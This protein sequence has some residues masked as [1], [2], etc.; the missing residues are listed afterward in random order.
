MADTYQRAA[1]S[2]GQWPNSPMVP[3]AALTAWSSLLTGGANAQAVGELG[4]IA[5]EWQ[6][7][8]GRRLQEDVVL[9]QR[10]TRSTRP[11]QVVAAYADFWRK[12]GE[13]YSNEVSTMMKLMTDVTSRTLVAAQSAAEEVSTRLSHHEAR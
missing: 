11:D 9:L 1:G 3:N 6:T 13:D 8:V 4:A 10:L 7:F 12:A 2:A 5:D